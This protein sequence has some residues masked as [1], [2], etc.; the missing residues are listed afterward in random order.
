MAS[1]NKK[2]TSS[3]PKSGKSANA[4][5]DLG[6]NANA[7][8]STA[9]KSNS[10]STNKTKASKTSTQDS[11]Q[12]NKKSTEQV[13]EN[14]ISQQS[15]HPSEKAQITTRNTTQKSVNS[16]PNNA[17]TQSVVFT[18]SP[19]DQE[20]LEAIEQELEEKVFANFDELCKE[21]LYEFLWETTDEATHEVPNL[22]HLAT[23]TPSEPENLETD[24]EILPAIAAMETRLTQQIETLQQQV[25]SL[26]QLV[27]TLM[28]Q[29][30]SQDLPQDTLQDSPQ[31][32]MV[33]APEAPIVA[34]S[35]P[36]VQSSSA[37]ESIGSQS[38]DEK[39][40]EEKLTDEEFV[41]EPI[42]PL[43]KVEALIPRE[44]DP[45]LDRLS[46]LLEDF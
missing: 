22:P 8:K 27:S 23:H 14:N 40:V 20:L 6:K 7:S 24:R 18:Q 37:E 4:N 28:P 31:T 5:A 34:D 35:E 10:Q 21:A 29:D 16:I 32:Q 17:L 36:I 26:L 43:K 44:T 41:E 46:A 39:F 9:N 19:I 38:G 33:D 12:S 2:A 1:S 15:N 13:T 25:T 42:E 30:R 45:F 11:S 3:T